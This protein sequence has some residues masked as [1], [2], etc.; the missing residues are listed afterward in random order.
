[1]IFINPDFA[2][3]IQMIIPSHTECFSFLPKKINI[4]VICLIIVLKLFT[5]VF[6]SLLLQTLWLK[7]TSTQCAR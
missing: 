7:Q 4:S 2:Q 1:M 5:T 6:T 3:L